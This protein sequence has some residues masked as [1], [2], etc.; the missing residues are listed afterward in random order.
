MCIA[1]GSNHTV[2]VSDDGKH[3]WTFGDN[4][5]G[6]LG[7]GYNEDDIIIPVPTKIQRNKNGLSEDVRI[8][9]VS[10]G[11]NH[12]VL[13]SDDGRVWTFGNNNAGQL[14]NGDSSYSK[15]INIPTEIQ[16]FSLR[17]FGS[18]TKSA[19]KS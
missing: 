19:N 4:T 15:N 10:C 7:L 11:N 1:S 17:Q 12:T 16:D 6:Q 8:I 2:L 18:L 3:I 14:G 5:P 13:L 9:G